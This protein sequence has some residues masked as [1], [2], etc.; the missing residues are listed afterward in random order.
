MTHPLGI[1]VLDAAGGRIKWAF[2]NFKNILVSFSGGKDSTVMMHLVAKEARIRGR[3]IGVLFVDWEAQYTLTINHVS[4]VFDL[5]GDVII[6]YWVCLPLKTVNSVSQ[7]EPEW[8]C[9]EPKKENIWVR[10]PPDGCINDMAQF[11]FYNYAMTFEEFIPEFEKWYSNGEPTASFVGIRTK[12]SLNRWR[13]I[14]SKDKGMKDKKCYTTIR[15]ENV[16][17]IFP[18]YDWSAKDIWIFHG[19]TGLPYNKLYDRMYQAGLSLSQMRICEPYGSE[20][21]R[22]LWLYHIIEPKTW[23]KVVSR[24]NGVNSGSIYSK[25]KGNI[26]GINN[27]TLPQN[28]TWHTFATSLLASMPKATSE[29]YKNKISVYIKWYQTRGYPSGLPE[30]QE[31][32]CGSVDDKPS[33]KRICKII[34]RNDYW[35]IGLSFSPTKTSSYSKYK[36]L[37]EKRRKE[38]NLI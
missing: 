19:K 38:W 34:L 3:K 18:I 4:E 22:G 11:P 17:E 5:Y 36:T 20:Q 9:W 33:W 35:C 25:E 28:H 24:V 26:L 29:H 7:F 2:D 32:D 14:N 27:I 23:G 16:C 10:T 8:I 30:E 15:G 1:S 13:S 21:R 6:P 12:E 31:G 37:M